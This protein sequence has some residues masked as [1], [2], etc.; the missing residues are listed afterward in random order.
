MANY[1]ICSGGL[2]AGSPNT[3]SNSID[4]FKTNSTGIERVGNSVTLSGTGYYAGTASCNGY[5]LVLGGGN[6][7]N[8]F[9]TV[10]VFKINNGALERV[11][12]HGLALTTAR[13]ELAAVT[14]GDYVIAAGGRTA[15]GSTSSSSYTDAIDIFKVNGDGTF[16]HITDHGLT[17]SRART[18][19]AFA[20]CG[21]YAFFIGG[22]YASRGSITYANNIDIFKLTANGIS[23]I[24][25]HGLTLGQTGRGRL[26][27]VGCGDYV[28]AAGGI[29]RSRD[30][31][32]WS[33]VVNIFKVNGDDTFSTEASLNLSEG[34]SNLA[35]ASCGNYV[36]FM[37]GASST[38]YTAY[39][40]VDVYQVTEDNIA[41]VAEHGLELSE[42]RYNLSTITLENKYIL[43]AG[44]E[45]S[46]N[47][48]SFTSNNT[49]DV[50]Q[51]KTN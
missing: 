4:V 39:N 44:G 13:Y 16:T 28:L 45:T 20:V 11:P 42:A 38:N 25:S 22:D 6:T 31:Y 14:L 26:A 46:I 10:D 23:Q 35:A 1:A 50:F 37:G 33:N 32:T 12:D 51:V 49:I 43:A 21:N 2:I 5:V 30:D 24:T 18:R 36:F 34:R 15:S 29:S 9:D 3:P 27:A 47:G 7:S 19:I 48:S 40:T 8:V 41:F 17:L